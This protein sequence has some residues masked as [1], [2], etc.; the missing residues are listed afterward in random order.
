MIQSFLRENIVFHSF[1]D[2]SGTVFFNTISGETIGFSLTES[3]LV[4]II[5]GDE[6]KMA[7]DTEDYKSLIRMLKFP[8]STCSEDV[9]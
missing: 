4:K 1:S 2:S 6:K 7:Y 3:Q 5:D 9:R 8:V